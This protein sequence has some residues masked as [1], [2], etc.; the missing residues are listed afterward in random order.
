MLV[1]NF[2]NTLAG[3]SSVGLSATKGVFAKLEKQG[4]TG[5]ARVNASSLDARVTLTAYND[6][7]HMAGKPQTIDLDEYEKS[8]KGYGK[9]F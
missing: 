1:G 8:C 9:T 3:Y 6:D 4:F 7:G 2:G 5:I